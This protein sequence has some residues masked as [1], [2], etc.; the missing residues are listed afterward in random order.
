MSN[1]LSH[2]ATDGAG[3]FFKKVSSSWETA[4]LDSSVFSEWEKQQVY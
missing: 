2:Q 3:I 4:K 1:L